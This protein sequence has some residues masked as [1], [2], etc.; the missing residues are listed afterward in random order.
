MLVDHVQPAE[1]RAPLLFSV[2]AVGPH[3]HT[4]LDVPILYGRNVLDVRKVGNVCGGSVRRGRA[5]RATGGDRDAP[6]HLR[7]HVQADGT[8]R[9]STYTH[10][11]HLGDL[12][13]LG[14]K[15][16]GTEKDLQHAEQS[17]QVCTVQTKV[18]AGDG[19][20]FFFR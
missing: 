7:R 10:A 8:K 4:M 15:K 5:E 19:D 13:K 2:L 18:Y 6:V 9:P 1:E 3:A 14:T 17:V 12:Q 16:L 20:A 11:V